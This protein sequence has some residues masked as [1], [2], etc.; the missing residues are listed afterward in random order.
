ME[1]DNFYILLELRTNPPET[2]LKKI[3][4]AIANKQSEWSRLRNHPTKG[5]QA[6]QFISMI[7]EIR[8]VMKDPALRKQEAAN[9]IDLANKEKAGK[10]VEIDR[11]IDILIGKGFISKEEIVKLAQ[12]HDIS[13]NEIQG[14]ILIKKDERFSKVDQ[15]LSLRMAKGYITE[16]EINKLAKRHNL[17]PEEVKSRVYIPMLKN[18]KTENISPPRQLDK[19]LEKSIKENL[20]IVDKSSLYVFLDIHETS[21]LE[22]LQAA[23]LEKKKQLTSLGKKDARVTAGNILA[24]HCVTIFKNEESRIAY[25]ISLA[26]S[27]L[28]EL[29]SDIDIS[30]YNGK[31]RRVYYDILVQKA[32]D[33]GMEMQ[34]A[35]RYI[36][37][38]CKR[39]NWSIEQSK[40]KKTKFI[41]IGA[42]LGIILIAAATTSL[43]YIKFNQTQMMQEEYAAITEQADAMTD[44][45]DAA[46][47]LRQYINQHQG[48]KAYSEHV[49]N[50]LARKQAYLLKAAEKKYSG[51]KE[52]LDDLID[53]CRF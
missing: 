32:M 15:Q 34:E 13:E 28:S 6:Q 23:A 45:L 17:K 5:L 9:A 10:I 14:R 38:Y 12:L 35:E 48:Q 52:K 36:N 51:M 39:K 47:L 16:E 3:E 53:K 4:A 43:L 33:F 30:G 18:G 25:D 22:A 31:V 7:P 40:D 2:D 29:D 49:D 8:R 37:D 1:R 27:K 44:P 46:A 42:I 50:A 20:K 41:I 11:H 26:K 19:S 21:E 24:G